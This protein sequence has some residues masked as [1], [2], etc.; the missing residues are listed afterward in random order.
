MNSRI[1]TA[2]ALIVAAALS[3]CATTPLTSMMGSQPA[4]VGY[5]AS[6][7]VNFGAPAGQGDPNS[8][9]V[10]RI[11]VVSSQSNNYTGALIG[12]GV[13]ALLGNQIGRYGYNTTRTGT[14]IGAA[15]GGL[16]GNA[17]ENDQNKRNTVNRI[18]VRLDN[19]TERYWDVPQSALALNVGQRVHVQNDQLSAN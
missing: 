14:V 9:T 7:P 19:G 1:T 3:A 18:Y 2:T 17:I 15:G 11:D 10:E 13:G 16:I 12:A 6:Q 8:G 4:N 5:G